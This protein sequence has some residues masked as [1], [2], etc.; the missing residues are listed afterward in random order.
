VSVC[1]CVCVCLAGCDVRILHHDCVC[2]FV[3]IVVEGEGR[4]GQCMATH[5]HTQDLH[6]T[7]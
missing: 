2:V 6:Q 3:C 7:H 4:R 1:A 5:A